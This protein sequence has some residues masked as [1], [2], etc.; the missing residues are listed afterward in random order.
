MRSKTTK[1]S[2]KNLNRF[3]LHRKSSSFLLLLLNFQL[4]PSDGVWVHVL[5]QAKSTRLVD[6]GYLLLSPSAPVVTTIVT[7]KSNKIATSS[8]F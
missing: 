3:S 1:N 4:P 6:L 5:L 7:C 2:K 8:L